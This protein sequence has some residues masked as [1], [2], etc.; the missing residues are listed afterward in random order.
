MEG[1]RIDESEGEE[2][3]CGEKV[4]EKGQGNLGKKGRVE[5]DFGDF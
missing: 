2:G 1:E 3:E 5:R 4:R